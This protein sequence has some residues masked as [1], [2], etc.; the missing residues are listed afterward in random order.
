[1]NSK[2]QPGIRISRRWN[3][4]PKIPT[5]RTDA[6]YNNDVQRLGTMIKSN[7]KKSKELRDR[8]WKQGLCDEEST[9]IRVINPKE[10]KNWINTFAFT[11]FPFT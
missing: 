11:Q 10:K 5:Q 4:W 7:N 9:Q 3:I 6:N 2:E 8:T 1:M